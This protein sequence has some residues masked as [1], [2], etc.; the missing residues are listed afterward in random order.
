[1][2]A[3]AT[4]PASRMARAVLASTSTT[5][6]MASALLPRRS[7]CTRKQSC[8]AGATTSENAVMAKF[9][10][11]SSDGAGDQLKSTP[12]AW[13]TVQ[14][15]RDPDLLL[16]VDPVDASVGAPEVAISVVLLLDAS[17]LAQKLASSCRQFL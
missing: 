10:I 11:A 15:E 16:L 1:M 7:V 12:N 9:S 14:L 6:R 5:R 3:C 13:R 4:P 17:D 2:M 8:E